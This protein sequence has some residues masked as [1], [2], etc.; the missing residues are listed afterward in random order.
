[1]RGISQ[2]T[3]GISNL[4]AYVLLITL[5]ISIS[6]LVYS[7]LKLW[8]APG[9]ESCPEGVNIIITNYTCSTNELE[10]TL[11]NKGR[12][13][14]DGYYV[15][16]HNITNPEFG[17]YTLFS[18]AVSPYEERIEPGNETTKTYIYIK[19]DPSNIDIKNMQTITFI[20]VQPFIDTT[21]NRILCKD[22]T[23]IKINNCFVD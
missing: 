10:I 6:V 4:I 23:S 8:T 11:K 3:K 7:W 12:F 9:A 17:L 14:V 20:E 13:T 1:M 5:T 16:V 18:S 19:T 2:Q 21:K 15:R 22:H